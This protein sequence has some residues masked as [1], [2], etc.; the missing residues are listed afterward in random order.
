MAISDNELAEI[1]AELL[2][3]PGHEKVRSLLYILLT[4]GLGAVRLGHRFPSHRVFPLCSL[5]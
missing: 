2:T 1:V 5:T 3:R 4:N